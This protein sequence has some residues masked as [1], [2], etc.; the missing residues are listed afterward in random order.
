MQGFCEG[1][2]DLAC[3]LDFSAVSVYNIPER[4]IFMKRF[5]LGFII[6]GVICS[7]LTGF[8]VEYAITANPF[9]IRVDGVAKSIEGYNINDSTYFK[10][11]DIADA[12]GGFTVGFVNNTITISTQAEQPEQP[13][14]PVNTDGT[15]TIYEGQ[16]RD[17]RLAKEG[18]TF[19]KADGTQIVLKKDE[20][21]GVLGYGQ[22]VA[23]DVGIMDEFG[24]GDQMTTFP[25]KPNTELM[26]NKYGNDS[27][28]AWTA[29]S[30]Y[31]VNPLTGEGHWNGEWAVISQKTHPQTP[32]TVFGEI[33]EDKNFIWDDE[34]WVYLA[35]DNG[36][37]ILEYANTHQ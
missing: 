33:S 3:R 16:P 14:E 36:R 20:I 34:E 26:T 7:A 6:G 11:R 24:Q 21:T 2:E 10:L 17:N 9:P 35:C 18:D 28:G 29:A 31:N 23:P 25:L 32:G 4:G 13:P 12:V 22:G 1:K 15:I 19:V 27:T 8:A 5:T 37:S 30:F